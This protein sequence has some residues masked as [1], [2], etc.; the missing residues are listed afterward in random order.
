MVYDGFNK[1][2]T[3]QIKSIFD[4]FLKE[5]FIYKNFKAVNKT[6]SFNFISLQDTKKE[7]YIRIITGLETKDGSQLKIRSDIF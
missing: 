2:S 4:N 1:L 5:I 3:D 6:S 7:S